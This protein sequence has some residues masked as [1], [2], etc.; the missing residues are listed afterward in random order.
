MYVSGMSTMKVTAGASRSNLK[1]SW[2][3][4]CAAY[5][6]PVACN[7]S[8]A[9]AAADDFKPKIAITAGNG[10]IAPQ[11]KLGA[12]KQHAVHARKDY[13][14]HHLKTRAHLLMTRHDNA[15]LAKFLL[16]QQGHAKGWQAEGHSLVTENAQGIMHREY[17]CSMKQR[18][19]DA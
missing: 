11:A 3:C 2:G 16:F 8:T 5:S 15:R 18:M 4:N 12:A 6:L 9:G 10:L 19:A 14:L 17:I 7:T 13:Q 1:M